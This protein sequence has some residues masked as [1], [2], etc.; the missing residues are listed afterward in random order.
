M[1]AALQSGV[2]PLRRHRARPA[3]SGPGRVWLVGG[4]PGDTGLVTARGRAVL[5]QA[6]VVVVDRLGPRALLRDLSPRSR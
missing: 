1:A 5:A 3:G 4:G 6:D 2:L